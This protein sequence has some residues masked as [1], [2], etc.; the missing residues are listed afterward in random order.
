[1]EGDWRIKETFSSKGLVC[2]EVSAWLVGS[3]EGHHD[4]V[5]EQQCAIYLRPLKQGLQKFFV[6]NKVGRALLQ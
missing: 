3:K 6:F 4:A 2:Q 1:M 5:G